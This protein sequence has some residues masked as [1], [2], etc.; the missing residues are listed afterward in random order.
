MIAAAKTEEAADWLETTRHHKFYK[1]YKTYKIYMIT[2]VKKRS[3]RLLGG[4]VVRWQL[5]T[6]PLSQYHRRD[7]V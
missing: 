2:A 5:P 7:K 6:L 3:L 4:F 1:I